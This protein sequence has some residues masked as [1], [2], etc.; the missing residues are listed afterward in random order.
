ME[1]GTV[2]FRKKKSLLNVPSDIIYEIFL[3][4]PVKSLLKLRSVCK[5]WIC[6]MENDEF[7]DSYRRFRSYTRTGGV[8]VLE[9]DMTLSRSI[10]V[11]KFPNMLVV[12]PE[13][14]SAAKSTAGRI[15]LPKELKPRPEIM[16]YELEAARGVEG[17]LSIKNFI[18]NPSTKE[19]IKL[20]NPRKS[21][22][23]VGRPIYPSEKWGNNNL[24]CLGFDAHS[25]T[26]KVLTLPFYRRS[27]SVHLRAFLIGRI[28]TLGTTNSWRDVDVEE[29]GLKSRL[30]KFILIYKYLSV[31]NNI[32]FFIINAEGETNLLVFGIEEEKFIGVLEGQELPWKNLSDMFKALEVNGKLGILEERQG[33]L[34]IL[35]NYNRNGTRKKTTWIKRNMVLPPNLSLCHPIGTIHSNSEIMFK[36][37]RPAA[38]A[39]MARPRTKE[40]YFYFFYDLATD[41]VRIGSKTDYSYLF[42]PKYVETTFRLKPPTTTYRFPFGYAAMN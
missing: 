16:Y 40:K 19:A 36:A 27:G 24:Y 12:D 26:Y 3:R 5:L 6:I 41:N 14:D 38:A 4:L 18:L 2:E 42:V 31:D 32:F 37:Y 23:L 33:T 29:D 28:L 8:R 34:W 25:K 9:L 17:L 7:V 15:Q 1:G 11:N 39:A 21:D 22:D 13:G 10:L 35:E 30:G 20:P